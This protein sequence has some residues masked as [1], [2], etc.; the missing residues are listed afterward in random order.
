MPEK[1]SHIFKIQRYS[2]HDGPGIRT[3]I[4]F[5]GCPLS[6]HWCH[7]PESQAMHQGVLGENE[8]DLDN[9]AASL[10]AQIEKDLIFFDDSGG[11]VTFSGG[12]PLC[13]P[14]L[15]FK[16]L[17]LCRKK[18]IHT[19][20]DTSGY[21]ESE[22]LR[23]T[24]EKADMIFYDIK[25]TDNELHKKFTGKEVYLVLNNLKQ[26]SKLNACIK[27]RFPLIPQMTDTDEN[28]DGIIGFLKKN[29]IY[30]DI[31]ILPF[32][33]AG[34]GK[35]KKLN[36]INYIKDIH[37]PASERVAMVKEQFIS[38]GFHVTIGG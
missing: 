4:F 33:R 13:Q 3:T 35:Y 30:R 28:I 27:L 1:S 5:Q 2:I 29:T 23:K 14:V 18:Q 22:L 7:N 21:A 36:M 25:L 10:M 6:C 20:V 9:I 19:C 16:L 11:G 24:S 37:P 17:D 15:L 8:K 32:H 38:K 12:E 34:E 26:L 31:H